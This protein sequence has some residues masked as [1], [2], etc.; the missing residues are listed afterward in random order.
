[1]PGGSIMGRLGEQNHRAV[2][3]IEEEDSVCVVARADRPLLG[4]SHTRTA[5]VNVPLWRPPFTRIVN[6]DA[7]T[8]LE[9]P[10]YESS[11]PR[12]SLLQVAAVVQAL[13]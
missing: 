8:Q 2:R 4:L 13:R 7:A 1:M 6:Q 3:G 12:L 10:L 11:C 9:V 5:Q